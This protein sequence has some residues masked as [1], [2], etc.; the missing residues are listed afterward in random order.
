M[1]SRKTGEK[2]RPTDIKIVLKVSKLRPL[3]LKSEASISNN[4]TRSRDPFTEWM[5]GTQVLGRIP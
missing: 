3:L 2:K 4:E 5:R 1:L